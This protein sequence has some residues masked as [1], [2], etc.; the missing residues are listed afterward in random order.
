LR[1]P[2]A[3]ALCLLSVAAAAGCGSSGSSSGAKDPFDNALG[4]MPKSAPIVVAIDTD[5]N[6]SQWKSL[7]ANVKKFAF[8]GQVESSLKSQINQSGLD[9]DKDIKPLLGNEFVISAPTVQAT[10]GDNSQVVGALQVGDKGKLSDLLSNDKDVTKDGTSGGATLYKGKSG[11]TEIA[12]DGDVFV[13]ASTKQQVVAAIEQRGRDDRLTEDQFN[14]NLSGLPSDAL[15][16]L[17]V[18]AQGLISG[19]PGTETARKVKWVAALKTVGFTLS[20]QNDGLAMDFNAKTDASQLTDSDLPIAAGDASPPVSNKAGEIGLGIRGLDQSEHFAE[21]V[22][23][24]VSPGSYSTFVRNK[25]K[26]SSQLGL[27]LDKEVVDQLSG[28]A[29][30]S[31]DVQGHYA[32][33]VEPKDPAAF[34][35]RLDKF[36][37]VAPQFARGAGLPGAKLTHVRGLYKLTGAHGKTIYYGMVGKVFAASNDLASLAAIASDTPQPLPG[38]K[39]AV[40]LNAEV[41][42]I[43]SE[44]ISKAAGGGLGGAF[45]GSLATAPLGNLTGWMDASTSALTGHMKLGIK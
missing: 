32:V 12:Q 38:A 31:F 22:A 9:F 7:S 15:V 8:A 43:A 40:A 36:A 44:L 19:S 17:Y 29:S 6:G 33:R 34:A 28:N 27:D 41:A 2:L 26:I 3:T 39:G 13:V 45:G 21:S 10:I 30:I 14:S 16:R 42:K 4:Y 5:L 18:D 25:K 1:R 35:K 24:V 37:K 11:D 20:S 23:Q